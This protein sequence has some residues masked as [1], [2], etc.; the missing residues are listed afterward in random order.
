M[1]ALNRC[2]RWST[3]GFPGAR[4][5]PPASFSGCSESWT[6]RVG[7]EEEEEESGGAFCWKLGQEDCRLAIG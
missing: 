4:N 2:S 7:E 6:A 3:E 1:L 5:L